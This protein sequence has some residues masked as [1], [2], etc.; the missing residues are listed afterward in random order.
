MN[1]KIMTV[2]IASTLGALSGTGPVAAEAPRSSG[3]P[4]AGKTT[5]GVAVAEAD[6]IATGWRVSKLVGSEVSNDKNDKI[7]KVDDIIVAPD[8][9]LS[10]AVVQVGGFLGVGSRLAA[11]PMRQLTITDHGKKVVVKGA[12]KQELEKLPP[13]QYAD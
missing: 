11:L 8:G 13:F 7:G 9:S 6:L 4:V 2:I 10:V 5:L 12:S 1:R 3:A